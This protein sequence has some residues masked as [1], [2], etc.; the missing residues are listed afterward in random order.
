M[1]IRIPYRF[2]GRDGNNLVWERPMIADSRVDQITV[3]AAWFYRQM[4]VES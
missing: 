1:R 4:G 3:N 2:I